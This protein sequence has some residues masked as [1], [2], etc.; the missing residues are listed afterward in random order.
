M[1]N[2]AGFFQF[3][4]SVSR[5]TGGVG[6]PGLMRFAAHLTPDRQAHF[7]FGVSHSVRAMSAMHHKSPGPGVGLLTMGPDREKPSRQQDPAAAAVSLDVQGTT[8]L[9]LLRLPPHL[10][11]LLSRFFSTL[12][13]ILQNSSYLY[14]I[15]IKN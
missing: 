3:H 1:V 5:D 13:G 6:R 10:A 9:E 14:I 2:R 7:A 15:K 11:Q 12:V 8:F 4:N